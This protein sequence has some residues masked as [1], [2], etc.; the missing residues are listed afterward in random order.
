MERMGVM[1][2]MGAMDVPRNHRRR[3]STPI[4]HYSTT[5]FFVRLNSSA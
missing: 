4:I 3:S 2:M 1:G 5:P